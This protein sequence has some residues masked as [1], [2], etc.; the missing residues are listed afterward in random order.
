MFTK[1]LLALYLYYF[2]GPTMAPGTLKGSSIIC[3]W[4]LTVSVATKFLLYLGHSD[5]FQVVVGMSFSETFNLG[6]YFD[7]GNLVLVWTG[8]ILWATL[9]M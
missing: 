4:P 8:V 2:M 5:I 3:W 1:S 9:P 6:S 7:G